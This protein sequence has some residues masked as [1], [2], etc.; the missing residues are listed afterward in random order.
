MV[1]L[2]IVLLPKRVSIEM[3]NRTLT[4]DDEQRVFTIDDSVNIDDFYETVQLR[5][6]VSTYELSIWVKYGMMYGYETGTA[7]GINLVVPGKK[8]NP[9]SF[10]WII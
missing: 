3:R 6:N 1:L 4:F 2:E 8:C 5:P 9:T 10:G 7:S